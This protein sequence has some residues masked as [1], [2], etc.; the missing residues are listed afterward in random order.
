MIVNLIGIRIRQA[1]REHNQ[2]GLFRVLVLLGIGALT[3]IFLHSYTS[4]P[5]QAAIP[6]A[7]INSL[8]LWLHLQRKDKSF[9]RI[10]FK[11]SKWI[12]FIEYL[13][14]SIALLFF[15]FLH[16]LWYFAL[17]H[18]IVL[19]AI[20]HSDGRKRRIYGSNK[21]QHLIP[22]TYFEWKSSMRTML[23]LVILI[24]LAALLSSFLTFSI[25]IALIL[26]GL[27]FLSVLEK[28]EPYQMILSYEKNVN[29][30]LWQ[31]IQQQS[32]M[33]ILFFAPLMVCFTLVHYRLWYL[34]PILL[35]VFLLIHLY[36]VLVKYAFYSPAETSYAAQTYLAIGVISVL[37]PIFL[38]A[39]LILLVRFYYK[40]T[41]TLSFYLRDYI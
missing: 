23:Y 34:M 7:L 35:I 4:T 17:L 12:C 3:L 27:F 21:I 20:A 6:V 15:L 13:I 40:A 36:A 41:H 33:L 16:H 28:N 31:K 18:I 32:L 22:D 5:E 25:P 30:F 8:I 37:I 1:G 9:L 26:L 19:I 11:A 38:P 14:I 24:E 10:N 39:L 2:L 29:S